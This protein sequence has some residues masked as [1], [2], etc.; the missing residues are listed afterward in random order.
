MGFATGGLDSTTDTLF[1]T[2]NSL[3]PMV[4][5]QGL[6]TIDTHSLVLTPV[7]QYDPLAGQEAELTGTGD[8]RLFGF[9]TGMP[10]VVAEIDKT[11]AKIISQAPQP[12][13]QIPPRAANIAFAQWGGDFYMFAGLAL[14]TDVYRY[15]PSTQTTTLERSYSQ[16][17][18]GA[19]VSTCAPFQPP[20]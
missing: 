8:G 7:G 2:H 1:V 6:A 14:Y 3:D 20:R 17:I 18:I 19:G 16:L 5:L 11:T 15:R 4:T 9:F 13:I 10:F 12:L